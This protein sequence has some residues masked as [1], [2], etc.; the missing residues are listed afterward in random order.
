VVVF[1]WSILELSLARRHSFLFSHGLNVPVITMKHSS[2][3]KDEECLHSAAVVQYRILFHAEPTSHVA[4]PDNMDRHGLHPSVE[5][6]ADVVCAIRQTLHVES[7]GFAL[8]A[9]YGRC[10][11]ATQGIS[12]VHFIGDGVRWEL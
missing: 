3:I 9:Y 4:L 12:N 5:L 10:Q 2:P 6:E 1:G 8:A 11:G 7:N